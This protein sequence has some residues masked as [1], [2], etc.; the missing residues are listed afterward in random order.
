MIELFFIFYYIPKRMTRLARERHRSAVVWSLFG[1]GAWLA[2]ELVVWLV[3]L[4]IYGLGMALW[5]WPE[6]LNAG[7]RLAVYVAALAAAG[8]GLML[9]ERRLDSRSREKSYPLPPPPPQF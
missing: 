2:G 1:I 6:Q 9:V 7:L 8:G 5:G 3:F 4:A